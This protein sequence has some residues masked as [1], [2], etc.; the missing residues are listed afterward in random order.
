MTNA[1]AEHI[2]RAAYRAFNARDIEA[3]VELM[4]PDVDWPNAWEG[5][6]VV[7]R[8]AVTDYWRRQLES[9]SSEVEPEGF[10]HE[11]DGSITVAVHQVVNDAES[12]ALLADER[13]A[14]RYWLE[15]GLIARMDVLDAGR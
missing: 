1:E 3:A 6:R 4:H 15:G 14:H 9:I 11:P 7:G 12:G 10:D 13:V 8:A 5:G 2:L